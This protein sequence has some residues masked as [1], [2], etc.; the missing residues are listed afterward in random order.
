MISIKDKH[1]DCYHYALSEE[2]EKRFAEIVV[3][4]SR[5]LGTCQ[6]E[7]NRPE[8]GYP[9]YLSPETFD[10][11]IRFRDVPIHNLDYLKKIIKESEYDN[12]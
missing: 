8:M 12:T 6:I 7:F 3:E 11:E 10:I 2:E 9:T 5:I 1:Y 4:L